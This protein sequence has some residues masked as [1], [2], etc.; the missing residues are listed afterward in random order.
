MYGLSGGGVLVLNHNRPERSS[1]QDGNSIGQDEKCYWQAVEIHDRTGKANI[2]IQSCGRSVK[3]QTCLIFWRSTMTSQETITNPNW[4]CKHCSWKIKYLLANKSTSVEH[5]ENRGTLGPWMEKCELHVKNVL[6][7]SSYFGVMWLLCFAR[8]SMLWHFLPQSSMLNYMELWYHNL[9]M[10]QWYRN[11]A[12]YARCW[13]V[14]YLLCTG[15]Y[16]VQVATCTGWLVQVATCTN[17][18]LVQV[19]TCTILVFYQLSHIF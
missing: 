19:A 9:V 18:G 11:V 2:L 13:L 7:L 1:R 10:V 5:L 12:L 15:W 4:L 14:M 16:F 8:F 17:F 3:Y 6:S